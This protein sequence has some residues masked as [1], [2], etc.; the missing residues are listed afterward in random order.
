MDILLNNTQLFFLQCV[1]L[2]NTLKPSIENE[3]AVKANIVFQLRIL[4]GIVVFVLN[5]EV[6]MTVEEMQKYIFV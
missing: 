3:C 6:K 1:N 2:Q 5:F 4:F